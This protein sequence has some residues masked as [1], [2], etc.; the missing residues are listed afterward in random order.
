MPFPPPARRRVQRF[1]LTGAQN[2]DRDGAA[3]NI[4][5]KLETVEL[6]PCDRS[7][8]KRTNDLDKSRRHNNTGAEPQDPVQRDPRRQAKQ[9]SAEDDV[10]NRT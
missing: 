4:C 5:S 9:E 2:Q 6:I 7:S 1:A 3:L 10:A 8:P